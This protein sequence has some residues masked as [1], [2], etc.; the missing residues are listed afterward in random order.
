MCGHPKLSNMSSTLTVGTLRST[1]MNP[2][3]ITGST[4]S[5]HLST[6]TVLSAGRSGR[7]NYGSEVL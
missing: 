2:P 5:P 3:A 6:S 4:S 7:S 1:G